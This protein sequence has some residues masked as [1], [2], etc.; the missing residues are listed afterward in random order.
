MSA[1]ILLAGAAGACAAVALAGLADVLAARRR[2]RPHTRRAVLPLVA[3]LARTLT[4]G[5]LRA[6][7]RDLQAALDAAGAPASLTPADVLALEAGAAIAAAL[8]A[9]PLASFAPGRLGTLVLVAAPA[10]G[11]LA[12]TVALRRRARRR[13]ARVELELPDVAELL[14][15]AVDAGLPP[16]RALA[17]VGRRHPGVLAAELRAAAARVGLGVA[18]HEALATLAARAP[19]PGVIA[20]SAALGRAA[21]H[22]A[23]LGP[24]LHALAAD[25]RAERA[26][27]VRDAA[28]RAAPK[29]QLVVALLLVP[30]VLLLVAAALAAAL[31]GGQTPL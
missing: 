18:Q 31:G 14:R 26:R 20:L 8:A 30:A 25:A 9:V 10:V 27:R 29:I 22:G 16:V 1:A 6:G 7:T 21:R 23:P 11:F 19:V 5:R 24:V 13:A 3:T 12:P 2:H 28:A 15:V 4:G 17:E